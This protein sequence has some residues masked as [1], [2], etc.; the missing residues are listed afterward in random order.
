MC[1]NLL[2]KWQF[3]WKKVI[4]MWDCPSK[5]QGQ[6]CACVCHQ[7]L[8]NT[9]VHN[10]IDCMNLA[11]GT[12]QLQVVQGQYV[13]HEINSERHCIVHVTLSVRMRI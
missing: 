3:L 1:K 7:T 12:S 8:H 4:K 2:V 5:K 9:S 11:S 13:V 6:L 10:Y